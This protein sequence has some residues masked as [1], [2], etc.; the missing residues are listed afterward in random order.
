[1]NRD[2]L[3]T[4]YAEGERNFKGANL[5]GAYLADAYLRGADLKG[6]DLAGANLA[7]ANLTGAHLADAN[8]TGAH[9]ADANLAGANLTGAHL[10]DANLTGAYL[11]GAD[12]KGAD[13]PHFQICPEEGA[14]IGYKKLDSGVIAL[15]IPAEAKRTSS[16]VGRKCRAEF[17]MPHGS[18]TSG[19]GG[20]YVEGQMYFPD[21]YDNDIR[22]E[23]T[24]GV[25]F[26]ITRQEAEEYND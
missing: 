14:F 25:H 1:M 19:R 13:L 3:L 12:L 24:H 11:T 4:A 5:T 21:S 8:L 16:L 26:L 15:T 17:V 22:V 10:A 7:G 23:C 20:V 18:G 6:A 2:E 9:L